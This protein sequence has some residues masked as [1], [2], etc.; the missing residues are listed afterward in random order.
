M[1]FSGLP[2]S[3]LQGMNPLGCNVVAQAGQLAEEPRRSERF[4]SGFET[5]VSQ[6]WTA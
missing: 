1:F 5:G 3:K 6:P 2:R 4:L